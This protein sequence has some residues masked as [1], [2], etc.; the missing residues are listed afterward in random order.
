MEQESFSK[1]GTIAF[2]KFFIR[3]FTKELI[4]SSGAT[5]IYKLQKILENDDRAK[6]PKEQIKDKVR[7]IIKAKEMEVSILSKERENKNLGVL[8]S[9]RKPILQKKSFSFE[10]FERVK[11]II[12]ETQLPERFRYLKPVP[13]DKQIILGKIDPLISDPFVKI[14]ECDGAGENIVVKGNMGEKKT[15][16][17]LNKNEIEDVINRFSRETKIPVQEGIYK[18]VF[19]RLVFLAIISEVVGSKF[20][21]RKMNF[22]KSRVSF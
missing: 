2:R 10:P 19:G 4:R 6:V 9:A 13:T 14:I 8:P 18:V 20:I 1:F 11:L 22:P 15:G 21:I 7:E 3:E 12:P 5:Q 17:I 16:I